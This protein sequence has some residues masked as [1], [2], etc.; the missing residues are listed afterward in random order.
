M[1]DTLKEIDSKELKLPDTIFVR[2]IENRVFQSLAL[3]C[4]AKIEGID[5]LEGGFIDTLLGRDLERVKGIFVEQDEKSHSVN[6]KIE[7]NVFYGICIPEKAEEIQNKLVEEI[8]VLTGLHV[9][10]VHIIF[11]NMVSKRVKQTEDNPL[12]TESSSYAQ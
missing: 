7:I 10:S 4:L 8:S 1:Y 6:L 2:D 12:T 11:K 3:Q 9:G 5:L